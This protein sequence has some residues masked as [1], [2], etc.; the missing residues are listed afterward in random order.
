MNTAPA[1]HLEADVAVVG[2]GLAGLTAARRL[3]ASGVD[4]VVL[5]GRD[6][7]GG[8]TLNLE[9]DDG[10]VVEIGGQWVG[11]TQDR[12]L[13]LISELG[14]ETFPTYCE[15]KNVLELGGRIST[16]TGTIPRVSPLVLLEME[17]VRRRLARMQ[18]EVPLEDPW[19]APLAREWDAIPFSQWMSRTT[20]SRRVWDLFRA[21]AAVV[22][23]AD[24]SEFSLLWALFYMRSGG[25]LDALLDT[26]GG[27]QQDRLVG[28]SQEISVRLAD[29]LGDRVALGTRVTRMVADERGVSIETSLGSAR[30]RRAVVALPPPLCTG[31][32]FDASLGV[33]RTQLA[34]RMPMGSVIKATAIYSA[35]FWREQG[36]SGEAVS[37]RGPVCTTFDNSP[38]A[39]D[40]GAMLGFIGA[41]EAAAHARLGISERRRRTLE[42]FAR[43]YG[44]QALRPLAY[45]EQVWGEEDMSGGGPV[46]SPTPGTLTAYGDALRS[47]VGRLHWAGSEAST[48]WAGY[49]DGAVR[50][51]ERAANEA[52]AALSADD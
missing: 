25:G 26:R 34:S 47:P 27:A 52:A 20:R 5:E 16:Y 6:R 3:S 13:G 31:I 28:G 37:D 51:G 36:F 9:L 33:A 1:R 23:G 35:P 4:V 50:S 2:G 39:S 41:R 7:V 30:A 45:H 18:E 49:M 46:C 22:W 44:D 17:R 29:E 14:M 19:N 10:D 32:E 24:P 40:K 15:G 43:L 38:Y 21:A 42:A 48:V 12:V 8:R 11:P